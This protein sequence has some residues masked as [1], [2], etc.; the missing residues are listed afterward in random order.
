M[1]WNHMGMW[2]VGSMI[3]SW[4]ILLVVIA[5]IVLVVLKFSRKAPQHPD[6]PFWPG[7]A[8]MHHA[9]S[10]AEQILAERY[11]RGEIDTEEYRTRL[12]T[13]RGQG[14]M[15]DQGPGQGPGP[16]GGPAPSV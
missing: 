5:A 8:A 15:P 13:L 11:A 9:T 2:G 12:Q 6:R 10:S 14:P 1:G 16:T 3:L 4:I 7:T